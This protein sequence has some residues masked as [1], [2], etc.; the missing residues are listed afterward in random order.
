MHA[1]ILIT[2]HINNLRPP[3]KSRKWQCAHLCTPS[4]SKRICEQTDQKQQTRYWV[5]KW[6]LACG[7][8][9]A[10]SM[11]WTSSLGGQDMASTTVG[12]S[13]QCENTFLSVHEK[14]RARP[15]E[16]EVYDLK[17]HW[18]LQEQPR[19]LPSLFL[20]QNGCELRTIKNHHQ[21]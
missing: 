20:L 1:V 5:Y 12:Q 19:R 16:T 17:H 7:Q 4:W 3:W 11:C 21:W 14:L 10:L 18:S 9:C 2:G 8:E 15:S 6:H 13:W